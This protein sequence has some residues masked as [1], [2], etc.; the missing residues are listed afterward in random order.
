VPYVFWQQDVYSDAIGAIARYRL[1][2]PGRVVG[3]LADRAERRVA[4]GAR[5]VVA[6]SST[7]TDQLEAW[8]VAADRVEVIPNWGAI[9]EMPQRPR[10]NAWARAH[11][12]ADVPVVM[13]AGTLGLK[14][15]PSVLATLPAHLPTGGQVVV[16]SQGRGREWLEA[17]A[18]GAEGLLLLD[19][20]PYEVLPDVLATADV[21]LVVLESDAS[22]YSVPSKVLN[23]LCVGRPVV[24][25]LPAD[26][27]VAQM[28]RDSG[29]GVV[30]PSADG[31]AQ[32]VRRLLADPEE[33]AARGAAARA[34]AEEVFD[35]TSVGDRF[36]RVLTR[37]SETR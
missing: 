2:P 29:A 23:Y 34:Y 37:A 22:R 18:P 1:G 35:V 4:R 32:E 31:V 11:G 17:H 24:A 28:L 21:L 14:H 26:N 25:A 6:I 5:S 27:A 10:D 36:E 12:L 7:F 20:Q 13:Y 8:G 16:V 33:R 19:Y 30:V 9:D 3:W 15:D